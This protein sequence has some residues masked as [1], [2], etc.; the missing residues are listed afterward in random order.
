MCGIGIDYKGDS[1]FCGVEFS[2]KRAVPFHVFRH[3]KC[4]QVG[5]LLV[6]QAVPIFCPVTLV[7]I[8]APGSQKLC[9]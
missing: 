3:Q 9:E 6:A 8:Y 7:F 1:A 4:Q 5:Q 2:A